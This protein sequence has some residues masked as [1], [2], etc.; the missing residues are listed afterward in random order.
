MP[1]KA[2]A[3]KGQKS[4]SRVVISSSEEEKDFKSFEDDWESTVESEDILNASTEED[5]ASEESGESEAASSDEESPDPPRP[6]AK[7]KAKSKGAPKA[8]AGYKKV[9]HP[10][11][12]Y[13]F[14]KY[15]SSSSDE[16]SDE[17]RTPPKP[18][19]KLPAPDPG[20]ECVACTIKLT[21]KNT[22][23]CACSSRACRD[24]YKQYI[25]LGQTPA[26]CMQCGMF[27]SAK[28][29]IAKFGGWEKSTAEGGYRAHLKRLLFESQKARIP[30]VLAIYGDVSGIPEEIRMLKEL[31]Q[32][33]VEIAAKIR[34][35]K[36]RQ[37]ELN[38]EYSRLNNRE[39]VRKR[40]R[41]PTDDEEVDGDGELA[42]PDLG[43]KK[44]KQ[45]KIVCSC[46]AE[47]CRGLI[48]S[49]DHKCMVNPQH[50]VCR[51]CRELLPVEEKNNSKKKVP[52]VLS[53][54]SG[55]AGHR[56]NPDSVKSVAL[57]KD[58]SV[59]CPTCGAIV[60]RIDGCNAM[61]CTMCHTG[62]DYRTGKVSQTTHNPH[63]IEWQMAH[64]GTTGTAG[65]GGRALGEYAREGI[66]DGCGNNIRV[67][68]F[69]FYF[70]VCSRTVKN[71]TLID[72]IRVIREIF[73]RDENPPNHTYSILLYTIGQITEAEFQ[74]AMFRKE[75]DLAR[76]TARN[77]IFD[78]L[79]VLLTEKVVGLLATLKGLW[80][81][82]NSP[83]KPVA[84]KMIV[85]IQN[86]E[87]ECE[88]IRIFIN[89]TF[90]EE[91]KALGASNPPQIDKGWHGA[92]GI[93]G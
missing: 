73:L 93:Y 27:W 43:G 63:L 86:F 74:T 34:K 25:L 71:D 72:I 56:C 65:G 8:K 76:L 69:G 55:P 89:R 83:P 9:V 80:G 23:E 33:R 19:I 52:S 35:L 40:G 18:T 14:V 61:W 2:S 17:E 6:K 31:D 54:P 84:N 11:G 1:P 51:K 79:R 28:D 21:S 30:E 24:C 15:R 41:V 58:D 4:V 59:P 57:F 16:P 49:K 77:Q 85:A 32:E 38:R 42:N 64:G 7:P 36:M 37:K 3:K 5:L 70:K 91:M 75:R 53:A 45:Y 66:S 22:I 46:P 50:E 48:S 88:E 10:K 20:E 82:K 67:E 29:I 92:R 90:Q 13:A 87:K 62:F 12:G 81:S 44:V 78:T 39:A 60:F 47:G 26:K 68:D